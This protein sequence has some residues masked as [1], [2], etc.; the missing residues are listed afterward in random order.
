MYLYFYR[1]WDRHFR[2]LYKAL[3]YVSRYGRQGAWSELEQL[4]GTEL[5]R[6]VRFISDAVEKEAKAAK[7]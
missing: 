1:D 6:R 2:D 4:T 7:G 3:T 5:W